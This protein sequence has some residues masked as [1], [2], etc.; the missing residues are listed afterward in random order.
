MI[1]LMQRPILWNVQDKCAKIDAHD[2]MDLVAT[3][4]AEDRHAI[5]DVGVTS[6]TFCEENPSHEG[7][8]ILVCGG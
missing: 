5:G 2:A 3:E 8:Q 6:K 4:I 1:S 7:D